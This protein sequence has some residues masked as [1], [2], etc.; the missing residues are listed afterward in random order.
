MIEARD[1]DNEIVGLWAGAGKE[2]EEREEAGM[3]AGA[4]ES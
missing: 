4:K 2:S 3:F 1:A